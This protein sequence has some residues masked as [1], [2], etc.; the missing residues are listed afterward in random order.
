MPIKRDKS[1][2]KKLKC[3][4]PNEKGKKCGETIT[5]NGQCPVHGPWK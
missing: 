3:E 1:G 2:N 4:L 5:A